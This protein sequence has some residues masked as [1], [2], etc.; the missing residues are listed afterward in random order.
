MMDS[1]P[2][3]PDFKVESLVLK[4]DLLDNN[5]KPLEEEVEF[6]YR[7]P[8]ECVKEILGN[9]A[10]RPH[11]KYAPEKMHQDLNRTVRVYEG[12]HTADWWWELQVRGL[13]R[14]GL[15]KC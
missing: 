10:L 6:W 11:I 12:I 9:P 2:E 15:Y 13:H 5:K 3:G 14:W 7:D 4:G 1:L 8:I